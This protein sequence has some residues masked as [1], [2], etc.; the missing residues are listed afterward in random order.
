[1][2]IKLIRKLEQWGR[3]E[4][5]DI[6]EQSQEGLVWTN[7]SEGLR[8]LILTEDVSAEYEIYPSTIKEYFVYI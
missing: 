7:K 3:W 2:K 6:F 4:V 5:G 8:S 1:M